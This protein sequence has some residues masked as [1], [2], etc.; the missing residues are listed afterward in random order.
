MAPLDELI[1]I[2]TSLDSEEDMAR[3]FSEIF[4]ERELNDMALRWQLVKELHNGH[5]QRQIAAR[6]KIS[7]C[8]ITRGSK[9]LKNPDSIIKRLLSGLYGNGE[10]GKAQP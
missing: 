1:R 3:F 7:L 6:H 5:T 8:K 10:K 4:T 9:I 2:F